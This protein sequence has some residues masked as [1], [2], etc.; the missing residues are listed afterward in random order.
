MISY[1][2]ASVFSSEPEEYVLKIHG[3]DVHDV[4]IQLGDF[5][6]MESWQ[7]CLNQDIM[8]QQQEMTRKITITRR[9]VVSSSSSMT[10][11]QPSVEQHNILTEEDQ[12]TDTQQ[13]Q[14]APILLS[15]P[16]HYQSRRRRSKSHPSILSQSDSPQVLQHQ[17]PLLFSSLSYSSTAPKP[18]A[19][20][21]KRRKTS[22]EDGE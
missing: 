20:H 2:H 9:R 18:S 7:A 4:Y 16:N 15:P 8:K 17:F 3:Q 19:T 14:I 13:E 12:I 10:L 1:T 6:T 5:L 11:Q 22:N 21:R